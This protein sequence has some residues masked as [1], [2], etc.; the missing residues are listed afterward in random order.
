MGELSYY[1][2]ED[3]LPNGLEAEI[4]EYAQKPG[5]AS[6]GYNRIK[7]YKNDSRRVVMHE[8]G[9]LVNKQSDFV[10]K[11]TAEFFEYRVKG[12]KIEKLAEIEQYTGYGPEEVAIKDKFLDAYMVRFI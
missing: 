6:A 5:R 12:Y 1:V 2:S 8:A 9:H 3:V 10:K 4:L 7:L 11:Q